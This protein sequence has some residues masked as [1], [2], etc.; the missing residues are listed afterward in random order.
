MTD[1]A[2]I[3]ALRKQGLSYQA[4]GDHLGIT[5]DAARGLHT[6]GAARVAELDRHERPDAG[7]PASDIPVSA[8]LF[9]PPESPRSPSPQYVNFSIGFY[10]L[11]ASGL[12]GSFG[13][14]F[15]GACQHAEDGD[16]WVAR[17]DDPQYRNRKQPSDDKRL[18]IAIRDH[19]ESHDIIVSWNG[20]RNY[21]G[22]GRAGYD[23]PMLNTRL[24]NP[25]GGPARMMTRFRKHIDL[26]PE[27]RKYLQLHSFRLA[28][29]EEFLELAEQKNSIL[30]RLWNK[31][32]DGDSAALDYIVGHNI[33]D[34]KVLR[35]VF[36]E[37]RKAGLLERPSW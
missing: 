31:A 19:L 36:E 35:L 27:A 5:K 8:N 11:E 13:R 2:S 3:E 25:Q 28:A 17:I 34:V 4:I 1:F 10:D 6:R 7:L 20:K 21:H 15:S 14:L 12:T 22:K 9:G 32:L 23:V 30:P 18:A 26:L 33:L 24:I 16:I 37:F 29:V